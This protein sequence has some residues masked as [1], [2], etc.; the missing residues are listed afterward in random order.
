MEQLK[1]LVFSNLERLL[2][3]RSYTGYLLPCQ[4]SHEIF[5]PLLNV[6]DQLLVLGE[7]QEETDLKRFLALLDPQEFAVGRS[8]LLASLNVRKPSTATV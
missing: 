8:E 6:L 7:L 1:E 4:G 3:T 5:V 2:V